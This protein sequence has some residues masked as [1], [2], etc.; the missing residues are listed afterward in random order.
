MIQAL[1]ITRQVHFA[2]GRRSRKEIRQGAPVVVPTGRVPRISRLM[3]LALK[4]EQM[5]ND[6]EVKSFAE[7]AS[8]GHITRA[9]M[10]QITALLNLAPDIQ[11]ALLFLPRTEKG[12]HVVTE[13]ALRSIAKELDWQRQRG[14]WKRL[15]K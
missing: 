2:R 10:S 11:E 3:A 8:L 5:V 7:I 15:S 14:M 6:G 12:R 4:F 13:H 9:R 1:T